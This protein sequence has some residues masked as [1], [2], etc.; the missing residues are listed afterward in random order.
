MGKGSVTTAILKGAASQKPNQQTGKQTPTGISGPSAIGQA[1]ELRALE[2]TSKAN[3]LHPTA[4]PEKAPEAAVKGAGQTLPG[5]FRNAELD[6]QVD[7]QSP[8]MFNHNAATYL[9]MLKGTKVTAGARPMPHLVGTLKYYKA[10]HDDHLVRYLKDPPPPDYY[11]GYGHKYVKRFTLRLFPRLSTAGKRWL[12]K[13]RTNLHL[14]IERKLMTDPKGFAK[15]EKDGKALRKFGFDS[16]PRAYID[17]GLLDLPIED[18]VNISM[19]PD[20]TEFGDDDTQKQVLL[21]LAADLRKNLVRNARDGLRMLFDPTLQA[22]LGAKLLRNGL[23]WAANPKDPPQQDPSLVPIVR[24]AKAVTTEA[25]EQADLSKTVL[26]ETDKDQIG[27]EQQAT[28]KAIAETLKS[29][30]QLESV[31]I[32]GH[33]DS[34]GSEKHNKSLSQRR[35]EAVE[36]FLLDLGIGPERLEA[37]GYGEGKPAVSNTSAEGRAKNRRVEFKVR[38]QAGA[39]TKGAAPTPQATGSSKG[40]PS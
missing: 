37:V 26:F 12:I 24:G 4:D 19:T 16:H 20:V 10:R 31:E 9:E 23:E 13:T 2:H 39:S 29:H 1:N 7:T 40:P 27:A 38:M 6:R 30:P 36:K 18:K 33:A 8:E 34:S 22:R 14:A 28:L 17:A 3:T 15:L 5:G 21:V 25:S 32:Q 11:L 35:A